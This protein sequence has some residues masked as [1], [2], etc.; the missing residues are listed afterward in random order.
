MG[1]FGWQAQIP[2]QRCLVTESRSGD[3]PT[4]SAARNGYTRASGIGHSGLPVS[5]LKIPKGLKRLAIQ[6]AFPQSRGRS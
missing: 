6:P 4:L 5:L 2:E 1:C 3:R